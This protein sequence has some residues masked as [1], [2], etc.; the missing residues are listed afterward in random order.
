MSFETVIEIVCVAICA[1]HAVIGWLH[2]LSL[3][4]KVDALCLKCG[5]PIE[6]GVEHNCNLTQFQYGKLID[7]VKLVKPGFSGDLSADELERLVNFVK[8]LK[9]SDR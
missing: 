2:S 5:E 1:L 8:S 9:E 4:R 6:K 3:G 7:F